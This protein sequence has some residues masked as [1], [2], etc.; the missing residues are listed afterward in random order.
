MDDSPYFHIRESIKEKSITPVAK[1]FR[2]NVYSFFN[3][4]NVISVDPNVVS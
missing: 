4:L 1:V 2:Q 3:H